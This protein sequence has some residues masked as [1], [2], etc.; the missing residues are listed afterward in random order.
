MAERQRCD[1]GAPMVC[2]RVVTVA[3]IAAA[4]LL[5]LLWGS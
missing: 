5:T 4:L 1:C 2:L 3:T